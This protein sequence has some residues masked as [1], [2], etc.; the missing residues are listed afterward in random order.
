V[1]FIVNNVF[2][3]N[4]L[5]GG[6]PFACTI[7]R[8]VTRTQPRNQVDLSIQKNFKLYERM[9]LT[10]RADALNAFNH[11]FYGAPGL[12]IN[13]KN[14]AG[15]A[16]TP[17]PVTTPPTPQTAANCLPGVPAPSTY[18]EVFGSTGTFRSIVVSAHVTF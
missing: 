16:C 10:L 13:N 6:D 4:N 17:P 12:N 2:A 11:Q 15:V 5:C 18:G 1:H 3:V 7:G 8:N 9:S 14:A